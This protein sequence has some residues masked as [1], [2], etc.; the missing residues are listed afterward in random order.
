[1]QER[2]KITK[3]KKHDKQL[4]KR[5]RRRAYTAS[6][7]HPN[8]KVP[9]RAHLKGFGWKKELADDEGIATTQK[10]GNVCIFRTKIAG[11]MQAFE[12][13]FIPINN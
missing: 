4:P 9:T 8:T 5:P 6:D 11:A 3:S 12:Y 13:F 10:K 7:L 2:K 1:M